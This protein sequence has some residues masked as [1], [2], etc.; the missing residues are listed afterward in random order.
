MTATQPPKSKMSQGKRRLITI[1]TT[2]ACVLAVTIAVVWVNFGARIS[3]ALGWTSN[4]YEG[5]GHGEVNVR[6]LEGEIG[7]DVAETLAEKDVVKTSDAFYELLLE[8]PD[9]TFEPGTFTLKQQMSAQGA[10]DALQDPANRA[11]FTVVLPE[12]ITITGAIDRISESSGIDESTVEEAMSDPQS[13]GVPE[14]FPSIEGYLFPATYEFDAETSIDDILQ[15]MVDRMNQ[16]L[17][18]HGVEAKDALQVLTMASLIQR[19]AG[20]DTDDFPKISRVFQNRLDKG[21]L[22]ESDATVAYGTGNLDTVWTTDAERADAKNKYNTYENPGLPIGPIGLPGDLAIDSALHPADGPWMFFVP[23]NL[24]TGETKFSTTNEE[25]DK[26][27][28]ELQKWCAAHEEAG[29]S[30]CD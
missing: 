17:D 9:A 1:W 23:V 6:V 3:L 5:P 13:Y 30:H 19:E 20:S 16:A 7:A 12:G 11:N 2:I 18:E 4:D 8:N 25:H 15:R 29:G 27:V 21:I 28:A 14:D 10:F 26:A 24:D 22:L